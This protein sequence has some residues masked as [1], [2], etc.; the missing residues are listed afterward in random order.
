MPS[1][2][3]V[4]GPNKILLGG[5]IHYFRVPKKE[6]RERLS[7][8][9]DAGL[10]T[11]STYIPWNWHEVNP[12]DGFDF[13]GNTL[14][15]RDLETFL[16]YAQQEDLGVIARPGPYICAEWRNGGIPDWLIRE[17]PEILARNHRGEPTPWF[18]GKAPVITYLH[19]V[20]LS[21]AKRWLGSVASVL[22]RHQYTNGGSVVLIQIDNETSYGFHAW[23]FDTDY[24]DVVIGSGEEGLY[25]R[26]LRERYQSIEEL[27]RRYHSSFDS[28]QSVEPPRRVVSDNRSLPWIFDW[29]EFKEDMIADFLGELARVLREGRVSVPLCTNEPYNIPPPANISKKSKVVF[30]TLD[31][32]PQ[33]VQDLESLT[34]I[35]NNIERLKA[36]QPNSAPLALE[37]QAGWFVS[38]VPD[39][40]LHLLLRIAYIHGLKG[41]NL[42]MF[43]GGFNPR[44]FGTTKRVYYHD[45]PLDERGRK[46]GKY[47]VVKRFADFVKSSDRETRK[48]AEF[49]LGYY[50]PYVYA[51]L[52]N[53]KSSLP[54]GYRELHSLMERLTEAV[55]GA[56]FNF[57]F[58]DLRQVSVEKLAQIPLLLVFSFDFMER[59]VVKKLLE[60]V[61]R[62]GFLIVLPC[63]PWLDENFEECELMRKVLGVSQQ[64]IDGGGWVNIE[65]SRFKSRF[66]VTFE[67]E[68]V[69]PLSRFGGKVCAFRV[70]YGKGIIVQLGFVPSPECLTFILERVGAAERYCFSSGKVVL[71]ER[72]EGGTGYLLVCNLAWKDQECD[73]VFSSPSDL[74][75][76]IAVKNV[77]I[78]RRSATIW[79]MGLKIGDSQINYITSEITRLE[80]RG[81]IVEL[82]CWGYRGNP[83]RISITL[84]EKPKYVS[85]DST[86]EEQNNTLLIDYVHDEEREIL[87]N[88]KN[89]T[90]IKITGIDP[91][92]EAS[93]FSRLAYRLKR[94]IIKRFFG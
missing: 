59:L 73:V 34:E 27:N 36:E 48:L 70:D 46:T 80:K 22:R 39:N 15:E 87:I 2:K 44:G 67:A 49:V 74:N 52:V 56:G 69:E 19:P 32:Y 38:R 79:T 5:E 83:G 3:E 41:L 88:A 53:A 50:H 62:G 82:E 4:F 63:V 54:L 43:S 42:Y 61:E 30:D 29:I 55:I 77:V 57:E 10:N 31:L 86:W 84:P 91:P 81:S 26:W 47:S 68:G 35:V 9:K 76:K 17:H 92:G 89:K 72:V 24:N 14:E 71:C 37:V 23:P 78:P 1:Y 7:K 25:Q 13:Q 21:H 60:Y 64:K 40:M 28:F 51:K 45:A 94:R 12:P 90:V 18:F 93:R 65:G 6:W 20:Y 75:R 58:V 11:V 66:V 16:D 33:L 85:V 8:L